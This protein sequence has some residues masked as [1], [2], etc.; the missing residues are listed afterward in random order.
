MMVSQTLPTLTRQRAQGKAIT[1]GRTA[2]HG[3]GEA[4]GMGILMQPS[5]KVSLREAEYPHYT[6]PQ[7]S[8]DHVGIMKAS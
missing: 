4:L 2:G 8:C 7:T 1:K 6:S 3:A 5:P